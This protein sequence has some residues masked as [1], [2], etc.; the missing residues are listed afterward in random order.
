MATQDAVCFA[1]VLRTELIDG[2][3]TEAVSQAIRDAQ[4]QPT[5][6]VR[7]GKCSRRIRAMSQHDVNRA[8]TLADIRRKTIV[9]HLIDDAS[10]R[11]IHGCAAKRPSPTDAATHFDRRITRTNHLRQHH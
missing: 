1:R 5:H 6:G 10:H 7:I 3:A 9:G 11:V 8:A 2:D 4:V